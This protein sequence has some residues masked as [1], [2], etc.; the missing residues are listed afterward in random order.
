MNFSTEEETETLTVRDRINSAI[1]FVI[2]PVLVTLSVYS[3][4]QGYT[5]TSAM[6]I[7]VVEPLE[8]AAHVS[9]IEIAR[10][11][12]QKATE[13]INLTPRLHGYVNGSDPHWQDWYENLE[14]QLEKLKQIK[15]N[16]SQIEQSLALLQTNRVLLKGDK[17]NIPQDRE[18][19]K[20]NFNSVLF[21]SIAFFSVVF[22]SVSIGTYGWR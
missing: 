16:A 17:V 5:K 2:I 4:W 12:L 11:E 9:S 13:Y 1:A 10:S 19:E 20:D 8:K 7:G 6:E 18:T 15:S 21:G 14:R 22:L 3:G